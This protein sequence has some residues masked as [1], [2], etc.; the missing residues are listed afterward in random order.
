MLAW[1]FSRP[2]IIAFKL[3]KDEIWSSEKESTRK[4]MFNKFSFSQSLFV[5]H[6]L[7]TLCL[8]CSSTALLIM[9]WWVFRCVCVCVFEG[10]EMFKVKGSNYHK[11]RHWQQSRATWVRHC[12]IC[13]LLAKNVKK[14]WK[15]VVVGLLQQLLLLFSSNASGARP[16]LTKSFAPPEQ[17]EHDKESLTSV[18][19]LSIFWMLFTTRL[20]V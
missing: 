4:G 15:E 12:T 1:Y 13:T 5:L 8:F 19:E 16:L 3:K 11:G 17:P 10:S 2:D 18:F 14:L 7:W 9:C 20:P 6:F